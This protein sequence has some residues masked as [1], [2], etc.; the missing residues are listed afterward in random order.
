MPRPKADYAAQHA[1]A[2]SIQPR[3]ARAVQR[4]VAKLREGISINDLAMAL[5]AKNVKAA[6]ALLTDS[7]MRDA[8]GPAR[9]IVRDAFFR[10]GRVGAD[11]VN[12]VTR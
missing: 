3:L 7:S 8:L 12:A 9:T 4:A 6:T 1:A 11:R 2:D 10:G 5:H